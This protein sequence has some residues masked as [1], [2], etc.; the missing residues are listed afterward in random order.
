MTAEDAFLDDIRVNPDDDAVRLIYAD[1]LD[2]RAAPGD[3]DRAEF[4]RVQ[5]AAV[6]LRGPELAR[7]HRRSRDLLELHWD[8]WTAPIWRILGRKTHA[9]VA[10]VGFRRGFLHELTL[11]A[12]E[13]TAHHRALFRLGPIGKIRLLAAGGRGAALSACEPLSRL[14]ELEFADYFREPFTASDMM[15]LA[16]SPHL[17]RLRVLR[18]NRNNLGD[19]GVYAL[20]GAEWLPG[21]VVLDLTDNGLSFDGVLALAHTRRTFRPFWLGLARNPIGPPA[22]LLP[23]PPGFPMTAVPDILTDVMGLDLTRCNLTGRAVALLASLPL[24]ALRE[25]DLSDNRLDDEAARALVRAP[26]MRGLRRLALRGHALT[27]E[28]LGRLAPLMGRMSVEL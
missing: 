10:P 6:S 26:W 5:I 18:L 22:A 16:N 21:V 11:D 1:W 3:A 9:S 15:A 2:D 14:R 17:G 8:E 20:A 7:S 24:R 23:Q 12:D 19:A 13:L 4:I 27:H 25:L 28:G